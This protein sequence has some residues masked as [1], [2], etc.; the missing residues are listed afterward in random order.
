MWVSCVQESGLSGGRELRKKKKLMK[1]LKKKITYKQ[2]VSPRK[3]RM[4]KLSKQNGDSSEADDTSPSRPTPTSPEH[5]EVHSVG[6]GD[7]VIPFFSQF[8][9]DAYNDSR[10]TGW[11]LFRLLINP[12]PL[13]KFFE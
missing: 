3:K 13:D 9:P 12:L 7:M 1:R 10:D 8:D 6:G 2:K 11:E 4:V 5:I